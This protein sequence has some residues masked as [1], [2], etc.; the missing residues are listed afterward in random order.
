[1]MG[2]ETGFLGA[3]A[4]LAGFCWSSSGEA[5]ALYW[6]AHDDFGR[7]LALG[8]TVCIVVQALI[9]MSVVL[10]MMPTKEFRCR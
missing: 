8:V 9:N 7:Y 1:M 6:C 3:T 2:E 4:L 10:D 5:C